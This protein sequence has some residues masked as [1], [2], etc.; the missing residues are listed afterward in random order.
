[1]LVLVVVLVAVS[2]AG[3]V[4]AQPPAP[5][6]IPRTTLF[7]LGDADVGRGQP[8]LSPDGSRLAFVARVRGERQLFVG[9]AD[10]VHEARPITAEPAGFEGEQIQW[11]STG[12]HLL[13]LADRDGDEDYRLYALDLRHG[14]TRNLTPV[15]S[16]RA[17][18]VALSPRFPD[19]ALISISDRDP[20]ARD[21]YRVNITTGQPAPVFVNTSGFRAI[22]FDEGWVPRFGLKYAEQGQ[23]LWQRVTGG[24]WTK[25]LE[26]PYDG[27]DLVVVAVRGATA[28]L[29]GAF[30]RDTA[31]L[32]ALD[33]AAGRLRLVF[34]DEH[35]D[36][37]LQGFAPIFDEHTGRPQAAYTERER[38][39]WHV[40]DQA[41]AAD[42][43]LLQGRSAGVLGLHTPSLSRPRWIISYHYDTRPTEY[44]LYDRE[45]DTVTPLWAADEHLQGLPLAP[46]HPVTITARDGL[47]LVSYLTLPPDSDLDGDGRPGRPLPLVL[48]IHGGPFARD[49]WGLNPEVQLLANRGYAVLQVNFRGSTG[50]GKRHQQLAYRQWGRAMQD[51]L[52]DSVRWA[53]AR[54]IADPR[55]VAAYGASYGGYASLWSIARSADV[56]A[57]AVSIVGPANLATLIENM[58]R[59]W[60][61]DHWA[62]ALGEWRTQ[63]GRAE[64][65]QYS[66]VTYAAQIEDPLLIVQGANDPRVVKAESDQ[67]VNAMVAARVPVTYALYPD[68]GH[69]VAKRANVASS[70]ALIEQFLA[71]PGC[72]GGRA[73][74]FGSALHS[75]S[76]TVPQGSEL[77]PGLAAAL[78]QR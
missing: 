61:E 72:L 11:A 49:S 60:P 44:A 32:Y 78:A 4:S 8:I 41:Y 48:H 13:Y 70:F 34:A 63:R 16:A 2:S 65:L 53:V 14:T 52:L 46:M 57:C 71:Q 50:F 35:A 9:P 33:T 47:Q 51:D 27:S 68:E 64:L 43:A 76:L 28:Y 59:D 25:L 54:A 66:P 29:L 31:G 45:R 20:A 38:G 67:M 37:A 39:A 73:E 30:E 23:Q 56:F 69:G 26:H 18:V 6:L 7:G 12:A 5:P 3:A 19:E 21:Y 17:N 22:F 36:V 55:R 24:Q 74:P 75:S 42:I 40:L 15:P 10:A 77:I 58:P 62:N 1:M